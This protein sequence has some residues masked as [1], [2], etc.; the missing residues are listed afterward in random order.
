MR[1]VWF[2]RKLWTWRKSIPKLYQNI[3]FDTKSQERNFLRSLVR[4]VLEEP[5][6]LMRPLHSNTIEKWSAK[7]SCG[8]VPFLKHGCYNQRLSPCCSTVLMWKGIAHQ[9]LVCPK[10]QIVLSHQAFYHHVLERLQV[11]FEIDFAGGF[12]I[13]TDCLSI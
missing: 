11:L 8:R 5:S 2:W 10:Q 1:M 6:V 3:E 9:E 12:Y 4:I 13:F 7:I